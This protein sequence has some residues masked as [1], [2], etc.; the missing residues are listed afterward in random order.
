MEKAA[1][2]DTIEKK[3]GASE[4]S[5]DSKVETTGGA[6]SIAADKSMFDFDELIAWYPSL[7]FLLIGDLEAGIP[8]YHVICLKA[9]LPGGI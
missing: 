9:K 4:T 5:K 1:E 8:G 7:L 6:D 3:E 2:L